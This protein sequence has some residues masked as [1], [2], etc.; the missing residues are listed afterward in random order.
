MPTGTRF[1]CRSE[2]I[3]TPPVPVVSLGVGTLNLSPEVGASI[4]SNGTIIVGFSVSNIQNLEW[5]SAQTIRLRIDRN[6]TFFKELSMP[7]T[8]KAKTVDGFSD[9]Q[10]TAFAS[11]Y[12]GNGRMIDGSRSNTISFLFLYN[13]GALAAG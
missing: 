8:T 11:L 5:Y 2:R 4:V 3:E 13:P 1:D 7:T 10:Y 12:D 9:G 6:G